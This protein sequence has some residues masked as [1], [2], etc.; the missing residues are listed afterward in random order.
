MLALRPTPRPNTIRSL[1]LCPRYLPAFPRRYTHIRLH[2]QHWRSLF[3]PPTSS[4]S[5]TRVQARG[6]SIDASRAEQKL[7]CTEIDED[8]RVSA[9]EHLTR[10]ELAKKYGVLAQNLRNIIS[11]QSPAILKQPRLLIINLFDIKVLIQRDRAL[12]I[13][14]AA[15][16]GSAEPSTDSA[17]IHFIQ[18]KSRRNKAMDSGNLG[19]EMRI[20][21]AALMWTL[22]DLQRELETVREPIQWVLRCLEEN[23]DW[24]S[25]LQLRMLASQAN[26]C[27][28]RGELLRDVVDNLLDTDGSSAAT[29]YVDRTD[30]SREDPFGAV[31]AEL[32]LES[33]YGTY[34]R[35]TQAA[36]SLVSVSRN[37]DGM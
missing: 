11:S 6:V 22:L 24:R 1:R 26:R 32:L 17:M 21:E 23:V 2:S 4:L 13:T 29:Y 9:V 33:Y 14:L 7:R 25:L 10:G 15:P 30:A 34:D 12:F 5:S 20:L 18:E 3:P 19:Y 35:V 37:V 8:G 28:H 16:D 36:Q 27:A 31:E